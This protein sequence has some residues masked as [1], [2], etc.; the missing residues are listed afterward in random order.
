MPEMKAVVTYPKQKGKVEMIEV[1]QPAITAGEVLIRMR[2]V[3][4]DGT[5]TE[6]IEAAHGGGAP[7][8]DDYL[9]LGH[10]SLGQVAEVGDGVSGLKKDDWVVSTVRRPDGCPNCRRGEYDM[11]LWGDYTERG[12]KGAHGYLAEY[13]KE[14]PQ[15]IVPIPEALRPVG[16]LVEPLSINEKALTQAW[17]IQR[18]MH[19]KPRTAL[20]FGLGTIGILA[21]MILRHRGLDT[22]IYSRESA[23]TKAV[24]MVREI[25]INYV[26]ADDVPRAADVARKIGRIDFMLEATGAAEVAAEAMQIVQPNGVLCLLSVTGR[27]KRFPLDV[28]AINQRLVLG[29]GVI[30]GSVNSSPVHFRRAVRD[31]QSFDEKWPGFAERLITRRVPFEIFD[32]A[33]KQRPSDIK[34]LIQVSTDA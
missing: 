33:L 27:A 2:D 26:G 7:E 22:Y 18:R 8:G 9:I 28:A 10:E 24:K 3:G 30:F 6:V 13:V 1:E 17:D 5:D 12:I 32:Q 4:V 23:R 14:Q 16:A 21:A 34:V 15:F 20:V 25:G 29:N 31:L 19:W 11:C